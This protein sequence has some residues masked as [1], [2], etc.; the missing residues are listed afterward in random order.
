MF[1]MLMNQVLLTEINMLIEKTLQ[2]A[3]FVKNPS[4]EDYLQT[5]SETRDI[6]TELFKTH[7]TV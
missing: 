3:S 2:K 1:A 6:V 4:L 5:D 7:I